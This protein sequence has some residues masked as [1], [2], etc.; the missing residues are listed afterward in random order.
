MPEAAIVTFAEVA[1]MQKKMFSTTGRNHPPKK[2][3][4]KLTFATA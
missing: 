2:R 1:G 3:K 4:Q